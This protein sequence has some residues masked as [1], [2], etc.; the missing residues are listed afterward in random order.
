MKNLLIF[1]VL[2]SMAFL[3][4]CGQK[5]P[6]EN[7][8]QEFSKKFT[9][10]KSIKWGSEESTEWEAEFKINGKEMTASFD[11]TGKWM[12]TEME[13][14]VKDLPAPVAN[15]LKSEFPGLK[16]KECS[17][18]ENPEL[19]GFEVA[20]KG[21]KTELTVIFGSDGSVLKKESSGEN[22]E[23]S[24]G[25]KKE[26]EENESDEVGEAKELKTPEKILSA[27][28][29]KFTGATAV[30]W[31]SESSNEWEA[32]FKLDGK[33]MSACF[34]SLAVWTCTETVIKEKDLPAAVLATLKNE[35][36]GYNK[37]LIE[38]YEDPA[39]K[40]FEL[41]LKKG[42]TS[43]EIILDNEGKVIKKQDIK[44]SE[45]EENEK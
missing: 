32:E 17:T 35:F 6:P 8:K 1:T 5:N 40:G 3:A 25:E 42:E 13:L 9:D 43:V 38:I 11:A 41:V 31:G 4:A 33:K 22:N 37:S 44:E 10:A 20:L 39:L 26:K 45:K 7:I 24:V 23:E 18:I 14:S 28:T 19:Q 29:A 27:F 36:T 12:E 21:K 16:I 30:E 15:T 34:D 2:F